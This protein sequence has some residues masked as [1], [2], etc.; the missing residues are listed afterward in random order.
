MRITEEEEKESAKKG[1][2]EEVEEDLEGR[3]AKEEAADEVSKQHAKEKPAEADEASVQ[4]D[5]VAEARAAAEPAGADAEELHASLGTPRGRGA[6]ADG[7]EGSGDAASIKSPGRAPSAAVARHMN[8]T[9][10]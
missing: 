3:K 2:E 9:G 5:A 8:V 1:V 6:P 4:N 10:G 7:E